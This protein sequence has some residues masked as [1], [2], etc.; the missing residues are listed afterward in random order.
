[1]K[2]NLAAIST[3]LVMAISSTLS[4]SSEDISL[5]E[6]V[7]QTKIEK[8]FSKKGAL[9]IKDFY[10]SEVV[11]GDGSSYVKISAL[12]VYEPGNQVIKSR[13]IRIEIKGMQRSNDTVTSYLDIEEAEELSKVVDYAIDFSKKYRKDSTTYK[14]LIFTTKDN[15]AFGIYIKEEDEEAHG[16]ISNGSISFKT[17][18]L[19]IESLSKLKVAID[20]SVHQAKQ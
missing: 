19:T 2:V 10:R 20:R 4:H 3:V 12:I 9:Y 16:F 13:G 14:E 18:Y 15:I 5:T 1:M 6:H 17:C 11:E 7:N 8:F